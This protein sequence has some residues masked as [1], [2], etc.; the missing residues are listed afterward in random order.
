[1]QKRLLVV[2]LVALVLAPA[3]AAAQERGQTGLVMGF[4]GTLGFIW[5]ASDSIAFRPEINFTHTSSESESSILG[6]SSSAENDALQLAGSMLWYRGT[7]DNV[8]T[9]FVPRV[10][11]LRSSSESSGSAAPVTAHGFAV[12][13]SFGAQYAPVRRF[14]VFGELGYGFSRTST[15]LSSFISTNRTTNRTWSARSV[16]GVIVYF[17]K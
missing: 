16:V 7:I 8:R 2:G 11:Y 1:M 3:G 13:A 15:K 9:Y 14:S 4:P 10:A 12:Q 5:H 6:L 17:G